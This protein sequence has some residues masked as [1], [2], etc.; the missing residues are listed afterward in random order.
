MRFRAVIKKYAQILSRFET[1]NANLALFEEFLGNCCEILAF[2]RK[3][4]CF[5]RVFLKI[6]ENCATFARVKGEALGFSAQKL[7]SFLEILEKNG[8]LREKVAI[9]RQKL[10]DWRTFFK[11]T[12]VVG[13]NNE[14]I[15]ADFL[16]KTQ[17]LRENLAIS[18]ENA[19]NSANLHENVEENQTFEAEVEAKAAI[20]TEFNA[21]SEK[22][23]VFEANAEVFE[24]KNGDRLENLPKSQDFALLP[25][26]NLEDD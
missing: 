20:S 12:R 9:S 3:T 2:S 5:S 15:F 7:E 18:Q 25:K 6:L 16:E 24:E 4:R 8:D 14:L 1:F 11:Q 10:A 13:F 23:W 21:K 22:L 17:E 19:G 26:I